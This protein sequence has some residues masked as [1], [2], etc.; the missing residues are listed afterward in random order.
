MLRNFRIRC[1]IEI[2]GTI[3][4]PDHGYFIKN[5]YSIRLAYIID[6]KIKYITLATPD[7]VAELLK[8]H[9]MID[10]FIR[11]NTGVRMFRKVLFTVTTSKGAPIQS[12][13]NVEVRWEDIVLNSTQVQSIAAAHEFDLAGNMMGKVV[14]ITKNYLRAA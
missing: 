14:S 7:E 13:R 4:T 2:E 12:A 8:A 6:G 3:Q 1:L 5:E 9:N 11:T 10:L